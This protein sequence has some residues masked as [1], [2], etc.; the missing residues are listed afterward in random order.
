[1]RKCRL[2]MSHTTP[3]PG[4]MFYERAE[5]L[6]LTILTD[7]WELFD[8]KHVVMETRH[9]DRDAIEEIAVAMAAQLGMSRSV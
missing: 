5:E 9:L 3:Y 7:D 1:V 6:E 4:T 2:L 8:A